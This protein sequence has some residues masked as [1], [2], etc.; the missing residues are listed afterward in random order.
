MESLVREGVAY[1]VADMLGSELV[2]VVIVAVYRNLW[3]IGS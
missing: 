1:H 3:V 2:V